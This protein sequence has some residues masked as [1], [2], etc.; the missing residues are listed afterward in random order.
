MSATDRP[1][2]KGSVI[3]LT[4]DGPV[5]QPPGTE[6]RIRHSFA[7]LLDAFAAFTA[8]RDRTGQ[9]VDFRVDYTNDGARAVAEAR[10]QDA[11][12]SDQAEPLAE[13]HKRELFDEFCHVVET[14]EPLGTQCLEYEDDGRNT[15]KIARAFEVRA[16]RVG[17]GLAVVWRD[18]TAHVLVK[19]ELE[20]RNQELALVGEMVEYLQAVESS[21]EIFEIAAS[22]CSRLFGALS[23]G[24]F[25][26]N[27][28][29]H[30][31]EAVT[32]W[33]DG[34]WGDQVFA[35]ESCWAIRRGRR[36]GSLTSDRLPTL[37]ARGRRCGNTPLYS[38][39]RAGAGVRPPRA[40]RFR[41][42]EPLEHVARRAQ[43][44]R[45]LPSPWVNTLVS[46]SRTSDSAN[47]FGNSRSE[48]RSRGCSTFATWRKR[49]NA[50]SIARPVAAN[51]SA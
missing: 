7:H 26:Q 15:S 14:G 24:L 22:F 36:H 19:V 8:I 3:D 39:H 34:A 18:V 33:G 1:T 9:I 40:R 31:L 11:E 37:R 45:H 46:P 16:E 25:L 20:Q 42:R 23:G 32:S 13:R 48:I 44:V 49:S 27:E 10:S 5:L 41:N 12:R 38:A 30:D 29:G 50:R 35:P 43:R 21:D 47:H 2:E 28:S 51:Q 17:D 4:G 6:E